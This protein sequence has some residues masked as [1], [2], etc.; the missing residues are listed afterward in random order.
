MLNATI[1]TKREI[2]KLL[3]SVKQINFLF[4]EPLIFI[5]GNKK[6]KTISIIYYDRV[7]YTC[8]YYYTNSAND[9]LKG[10][11]NAIFDIKKEKKTI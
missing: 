3:I 9:Y 7:M 5:K 11:Y 2:K 8:S 1:V 6:E 10:M 4:N